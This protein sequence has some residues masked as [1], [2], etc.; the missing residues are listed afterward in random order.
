VSCTGTNFNTNNATSGSVTLSPVS[1][2][3]YTV[4]CNGVVGSVTATV[5]VKHKPSVTEN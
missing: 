3:T 1:T 5:T 2:T 4:T